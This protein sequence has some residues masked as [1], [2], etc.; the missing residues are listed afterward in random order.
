MKRSVATVII[1]LLGISL[2]GCQTYRADPKAT[3]S[4]SESTPRISVSLSDFQAA[5]NDYEPIEVDEFDGSASVSARVPKKA[6]EI[7]RTGKTVAY[8]L[9]DFSRS[10]NDEEFLTTLGFTYFGPKWLF[11]DSVDIKSSAG[12]QHIDIPSGGKNEDTSD[13]EVVEIGIV[14]LDYELASQLIKILNGSEVAM[15]LNG[16]GSKTG[17]DFQLAINAFSK[18]QFISGITIFFGL[19]QGFT[20]E[21]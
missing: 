1:I 13:G 10:S 5:L 14:K 3:S 21:Q 12:M 20:F 17:E 9:V 11:F 15:R 19:N 8:P 2:S 4:P 6:S 16:S 18:K 7:M